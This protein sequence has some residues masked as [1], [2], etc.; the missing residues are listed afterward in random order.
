MTLWTYAE[1]NHLTYLVKDGKRDLE[2][3]G[4]MG[5]SE[6]S[7]K[8]RRKRI[9][10][11][12]SAARR[13]HR[14]FWTGPEIQTLIAERKKKTP[15]HEMS[16]ILGRTENAIKAAMDR[17]PKLRRDNPVRRSRHHMEVLS[18]EKC[19]EMDDAALRKFVREHRWFAVEILKGRGGDG[20][21]RIEREAN[22]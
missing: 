11:S 10:L 13:L 6:S 14:N 15:I 19:K 16:R 20:L 12:M 17:I 3:A 4:I 8:N 2:I 18:R 22:P 7:V 21:P 5:K 9:G 1:T